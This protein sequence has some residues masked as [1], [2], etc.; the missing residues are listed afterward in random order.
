VPL[1]SRFGHD[2]LLTRRAARLIVSIALL[3][4]AGVVADHFLF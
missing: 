4:A 2:K 3:G 1:I